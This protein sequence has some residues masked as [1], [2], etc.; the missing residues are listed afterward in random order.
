M[1]GNGCRR[2]SAEWVNSLDAAIL[3][4]RTFLYRR[5]SVQLLLKG[6]MS[7]VSYFII[8]GLF[9]H[10]HRLC[11]QAGSIVLLLHITVATPAP[12]CHTFL[13]QCKVFV[14]LQA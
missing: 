1:T 2:P 11:C 5:D 4:E 12:F 14:R 10:L 7:I 8:P 13:T 9:I 3:K 6:G